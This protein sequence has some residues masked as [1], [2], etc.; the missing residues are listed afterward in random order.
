MNIVENITENWSRFELNME[1][2]FLLSIFLISIFT[3]YFTTKERKI[4]LLSIIAFLSSAI[5]NILGIF[6]IN[7][8]FDVE[9]REIFKVIPLLTTILLLS[10]LGILVGYYI[11]KKDSKKFK[12][13]DIRKEYFKDT[14]KQTIFLLLLASST[15]LFLSVQTESVVIVSTLSTISSIWLSY[16]ISKY[17]LK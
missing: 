7:T 13:S 1:I 12:I 11:S 16:W 4:L 9:I 8:I 17:I 15:L 10:N 6:L 3:I 5:L 14:I 2:F